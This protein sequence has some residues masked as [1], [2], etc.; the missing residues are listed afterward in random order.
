MKYFDL[1][2]FNNLDGLTEFQMQES[3]TGIMLTCFAKLFGEVIF[4]D[5]DK[6][7]DGSYSYY[8]RDMENYEGVY[9]I[10]YDIFAI[11]VLFLKKNNPK[12]YEEFSKLYLK[13]HEK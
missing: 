2:E 8:I 7:K 10:G 1:S 11:I 4:L 3:Y 5:W 6:N 9:E 13:E 12:Y